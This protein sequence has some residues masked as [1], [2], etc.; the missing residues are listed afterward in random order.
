[1][2]VTFEGAQLQVDLLDPFAV[3]PVRLF[4]HPGGDWDEPPLE[5][6]NQRVDPPVG[7]ES[8]YAVL[9]TAESIAAAAIECHIL[10]CDSRDRYTYDQQRTMEYSVVRYEMRAPALFIPIDGENKSALGLRGLDPR[11]YERHRAAAYELF[12][13]FGSIVHGLSW[14]SYQRNQPGRVYA[15]WHHHK[16]TVGLAISSATPYLKLAEDREWL[17]LLKDNPEF[18]PLASAR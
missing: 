18:E 9:Y 12:K 16:S 3:T 14:E 11:G 13:R 5:Y 6:R 15:L 17:Q 4:R 2:S 10:N 7:H 8:E 1:M